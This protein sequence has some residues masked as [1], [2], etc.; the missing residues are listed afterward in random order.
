MLAR[1]GLTVGYSNLFVQSF[2]YFSVF[3]PSMPKVPFSLTS[4]VCTCESFDYNFEI[5]Y[6]FSE[7][8][9]EFCCLNSDQYFSFKYFL[10]KYFLYVVVS[11]FRIDEL[12]GKTSMFYK[13][14]GTLEI[15][16]YNRLISQILW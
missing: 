3:N 5:K 9:K 4:F 14:I 1:A 11:A 12:L 16:F 10:F 6:N 7:C 8:L 13:A 15:I 2:V